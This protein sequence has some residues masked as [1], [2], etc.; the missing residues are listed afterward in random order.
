[1]LP[2]A[3]SV[4]D[5]SGKLTMSN[6]TAQVLS[7]SATSIGAERSGE[8][9]GARRND[10]DQLAADQ[11]ALARAVQ[12]EAFFN[13]EVEITC[14]DRSRKSIL[15]S[16]M[17]LR[18]DQR[19]I[20]GGVAVC[21]DVSALKQT[22][23]QLRAAAHFDDSR[24]QALALFNASFDRKEI[25]DGL[26]ALLAAKHPFPVSALYRHDEWLGK[27]VC[28]A[29]WGLPSGVSRDFAF[30]EGLL[31]QAAQIGRTVVLDVAE[32]LPDLLIQ[33]GI[34]ECRPARVL[35]VPVVYQ[36][37]RL[38]VLALAATRMLDENE[39]A[40]VESLCVQL[41]IALHN[42]ALYADTRLL[43]DQLRMR[44][45][46]IAHKNSQL[47]AA[48]RMKSEFLANMSHEMRT[49]LNAIIGFSE[50]LKDG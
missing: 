41:G 38:A 14:S 21:Q 2:V 10:P 15:L 34:F 46:E 24:S 7:G 13:E 35:L 47:E 23:Q 20:I 11:W 49:P 48:S 26:L 4:A 27:F 6:P 1:M 30:G 12:G 18:D 22:E 31:G 39:V 3:V 44:S 28:E 9:Q 40:F 42:L 50:V 43:A 45:E 32:Q 17:P 8:Q 36:E 37:R 5:A 25:S 33:A 16:G 19:T 29:S